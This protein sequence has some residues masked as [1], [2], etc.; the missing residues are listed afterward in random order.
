MK[1][2]TKLNFLLACLATFVF[3]S[4]IVDSLA[5]SKSN[6]KSM[7][8]SKV[9]S[10]DDMDEKYN[11]LKRSLENDLEDENRTRNRVVYSDFN[12]NEAYEFNNRLSSMRNRENSE[13]IN[14]ELSDV[15]FN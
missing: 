5:I 11:E 9:M 3:F 8:K 7:S 15:A 12:N 14:N 13:S 10:K 4:M 1:I 6:L 2:N